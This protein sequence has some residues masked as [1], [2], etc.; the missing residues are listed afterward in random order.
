MPRPVAYISGPYRSDTI[1]GIK[2][3]IDKAELCA[4]VYWKKG[5]AVICP[6]KNTAFLDGVIL[7]DEFIEGDLEFLQRMDPAK[8]DT[9]VMMLDWKKS[10]GAVIEHD[11]AQGLGLRIAYE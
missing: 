3:N 9:I 7:N 4:L 10:A 1:W 8:G 6:H 5:Y 2:Q 11:E